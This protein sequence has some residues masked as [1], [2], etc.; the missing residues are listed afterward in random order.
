MSWGVK[1]TRFKAPG[2][3]LGGSGVSIEGVRSLRVEP[4]LACFSSLCYAK[5]HLV[6][7]VLVVSNIFV[8][9]PIF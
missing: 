5:K 4:I 8:G 6:V 9:T 7:V 3:S 2:V 1:T